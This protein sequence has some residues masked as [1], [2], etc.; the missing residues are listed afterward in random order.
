GAE[1]LGAARAAARFDHSALAQDVLIEPSA[2]RPAARPDAEDGEKKGAA[3]FIAAARR[4][5]AQAAA[6]QASREAVAKDN[7][8]G[9]SGAAAKAS[10]A[11][12]A[13][14]AA[15]T[16]PKAARAA[17]AAPAVEPAPVV[18]SVEAAVE[19]ERPAR[20]AGGSFLSQ[21]KR[22]ILIGLIG[23]TMALGA[24]AVVRGVGTPTSEAPQGL[25]P[26]GRALQ[27]PT[28]LGVKPEGK[29]ESKPADAPKPESR[30]VEPEA[31]ASVEAPRALGEPPLP[32]QVSPP[33]NASPAA[34]AKK[35]TAAV[36]VDPAP[37]AAIDPA[38]GGPQALREA[39]QAGDPGAQ[40][41]LAARLAEGRGA[42]RDL[43]AAAQWF[44]K[45]AAQGLAP[46]QYRLGSFYEKGLGVGR[47]LAMAKTLYQ[48]AADRGNARA[49]HNLAVLVA[50]G[51]GGKP[52]YAGAAQW[53]RK[54]AEAGVRDSQYNLAILYARGLGIEQNLSLSY[55]WFAIAAKQGDEDAGKKRDEVAARLEAKQLEAARAAVDAFRPKAL[56][57]AANDVAAPPGGWDSLGKAGEKSGAK[58]GKT[59]ERA[60]LPARPKAT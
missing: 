7:A 39:A 17:A 13:A 24:L 42:P 56:D 28:D 41:E 35:A 32:A 40:F 52:D 51:A 29:S 18:D 3:S 12:R 38:A 30:L 23:L 9:V 55:H 5:Q 6:E 46:A 53:F 60:R 48:R 49:M 19:E 14:A 1:I 15:L 11:A 45:A 4:L 36:D 16:R 10:A 27:M 26:A 47:D 22:P 21:R 54:A 20:A 50:D 8:R 33:R 37:V 2:G 43:K 31:P 57:R 25:S 58:D 59:D 34:P 44:E